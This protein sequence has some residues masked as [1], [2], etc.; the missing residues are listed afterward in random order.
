MTQ[1]IEIVVMGATG[2]GKSHV[3]KVL[4]KALQNEYGMHAQITSHE[5][6]LEKNLGHQPTKPRIAET[7][8]NLRE[9]G[10]CGS[11]EVGARRT[12]PRVDHIEESPAIQGAA[13][14]F[15]LDPLEQAIESTARVL[16]DEREHLAQ[17]SM[18]LSGDVPLSPVYKRMSAHLEA[19][20]SA[21]L[22]SVE[23]ASV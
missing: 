16:R 13:M 4:S 6:S 15:M 2:S 9:E 14:R 20:L 17:I 23:P 11:L 1:V 10:G 19:L 18:M 22:K 21:Q 5:L 8:F 3:L 7:I 12:L